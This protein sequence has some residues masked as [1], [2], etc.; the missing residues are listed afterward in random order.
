MLN[1]RHII[2]MIVVFIMYLPVLSPA[3]TVDLPQT[4]QTGSFYT[5]DD[6][7]NQAGV[8][9]PDPRFTI[10]YC[11]TME[12]CADQNSDCDNYASNDVVIDNLTGLMWA[13]DGNLPEG[14]VRLTDAIAYIADMNDALG[15]CG[16]TD[17]HLPN[18]NEL[19][20][21]VN[22]A[23]DTHSW[24]NNQGFV[25]NVEFGYWSSTAYSNNTSYALFNGLGNDTRI[26]YQAKH[27]TA[28]VWPV[29]VAGVAPAPIW[30]TGQTMS[31]ETGDDGDIQAGV[32]WPNPRFTIIYCDL[33]GPCENQ[34][35]DCDDKSSTDVVTDNL[36]GIMW[37][38]NANLLNAKRTW[39]PALDFANNLNLGGHTDWRLPNI[40]EL[41][42][43][44]D[45][46]KYDPALPLLN[47]FISVPTGTGTYWS[48]TIYK[49]VT[50]YAWNINIMNG[51]TDGAHK[52]LSESYVWPVRAGVVKQVATPVFSP[53][54][55]RYDSSQ[56]VEITCNTPGAAIYYTT[57]GDNPT[58]SSTPYAEQINIDATTTLKARAYKNNWTP[59]YIAAGKY[60][61]GIEGK[62]AMPW[63]PLLLL[64]E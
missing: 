21:L 45:Y 15:L 53:A 13:R 33:T 26:K 5:G 52:T 9:W 55:G 22:V 25:N 41:R 60:V 2:P 48:S 10:T 51:F 6:G 14:V 37:T 28:Y 38:R 47:P 50:T 31:Y 56:Q 62:K 20:N 11:N 12:P 64:D 24:L 39:E 16:F 1:K 54:P 19:Q 4:G 61:I 27:Y 42:S 58:E 23:S 35:S 30:R 46:S 40:C 59:S 29:R 63:I 32:E 43:L 7:D 57:N 44:I 17:W 3:G 34:G 18:V 8:E 36:T 49:L